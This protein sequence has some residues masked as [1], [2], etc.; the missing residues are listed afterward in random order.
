MNLGL[1]Q[2][3]STSELQSQFNLTLLKI[4]SEV[5]EMQSPR[6]LFKASQTLRVLLEAAW[7]GE[8][9]WGPGVL[10]PPVD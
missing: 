2:L 6:P 8:P 1:G 7:K 3:F 5:R 10:I 4:C 9:P